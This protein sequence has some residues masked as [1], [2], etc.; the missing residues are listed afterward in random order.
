MR[1]TGWYTGQ[2]ARLSLYLP[3][4]LAIFLYER[5]SCPFRKGPRYTVVFSFRLLSL[6]QRRVC[7]ATLQ[8]QVWQYCRFIILCLDQELLR[9]IRVLHCR[10]KN[11]PQF[12]T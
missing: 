12:L 3:D 9:K 1:Y 11:R 8:E 10:E 7:I 2:R 5:E 4:A 6:L